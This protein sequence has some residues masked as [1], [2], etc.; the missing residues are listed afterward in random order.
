MTYADYKQTAEYARLAPVVLSPGEKIAKVY[1]EQ[2]VPIEGCIGV[3]NIDQRTI[4]NSWGYEVEESN[5]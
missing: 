1:R 2:V 4:V 3:S 5:G